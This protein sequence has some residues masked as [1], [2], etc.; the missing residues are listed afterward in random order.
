MTNSVEEAV[1]IFDEAVAKYGGTSV[2]PHVVTQ[3]FEARGMEPEA[4]EVALNQAIEQ[5]RLFNGPNKVWLFKSRD[6]MERVQRVVFWRT[7]GSDVWLSCWNAAGTLIAAIMIYAVGS[8]IFMTIVAILNVL[9][10]GISIHPKWEYEFRMWFETAI[11]YIWGLLALA[12]FAYRRGQ[13]SDSAPGG[14]F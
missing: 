4:A 14:P 13:R 10:A 3:E 8:L 5:G 2:R 9:G 6:E 11:G 7:L 1:E 12:I